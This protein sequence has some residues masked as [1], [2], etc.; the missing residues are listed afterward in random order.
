MW[1]DSWLTVLIYLAAYGL[2]G[3]LGI[4]LS[5]VLKKSKN[6]KAAF[7]PILHRSARP[8]HRV[9]VDEDPSQSDALRTED[10]AEDNSLDASTTEEDIEQLLSAIHDRKSQ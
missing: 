1:R 10:P 7:P 5:D 3:Y 2:C 6:S 9:N 4:M 8:P